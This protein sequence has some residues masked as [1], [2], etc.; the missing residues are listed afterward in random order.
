[1]K[2]EVTI[3]EII[4]F[5]FNFRNKL[6]GT[7]KQTNVTDNALR[8]LEDEKKEI[9]KILKRNEERDKKKLREIKIRIGRT[10]RGW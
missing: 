9:F 10:R 6:E 2:N 8:E 3:K 5:F 7:Q 4:R 1:M